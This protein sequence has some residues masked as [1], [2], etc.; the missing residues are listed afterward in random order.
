MS[1]RV[2]VGG[3]GGGAGNRKGPSLAAVEAEGFVGLGPPSTA[4]S[5]GDRAEDAAAAPERKGAAPAA[6]AI[7]LGAQDA[8]R[9]LDGGDRGLLNGVGEAARTV[10]ALVMV[11]AVAV[12]V[13]APPGLAVGAAAAL[14]LAGSASSGGSR[15]GS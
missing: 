12:L 8:R 13:L 15:H 3:V 4:P 11:V 2:G 5:C 1:G 9:V 7:R 14:V 10:G 6:G